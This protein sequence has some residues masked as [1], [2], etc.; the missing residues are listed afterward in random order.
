MIN[1]L[2]PAKLSLPWDRHIIHRDWL[3]LILHVL[4]LGGAV[5]F[6]KTNGGE[7]R[8]VRFYFCLGFLCSILS[9]SH[10]IFFIFNAIG[11]EYNSSFFEKWGLGFLY[12]FVSIATAFICYKIVASINK[13]KKLQLTT[14]SSHDGESYHLT[15]ATNWQRFFHW[16]LDSIIFALVLTNIYWIQK[17]HL[18]NSI[19]NDAT[20]RIV[21]WF[22]IVVV[23]TI[24]FVFF[25]SIF[26]ATPAKMLTETRVTT[27]NGSKPV[28]L[29]VIGR[30]LCRS[31]PF[32][33]IS[34]LFKGKWHDKIS[35]THVLKEERTG[36]KAIFYL[37]FLIAI[38]LLVTGMY[39]GIDKY[40]EYKAEKKYKEE[41]EIKIKTQ[42]AILKKITSDY[43]IMAKGENDYSHTYFFKV[44]AVTPSIITVSKIDMSAAPYEE[45]VA[46]AKEAWQQQKDTLKRFDIKRE[47]LEKTIPV[48]YEASQKSSGKTYHYILPGDK[49]YEIKDFLRTSGPKLKDHFS[50]FSHTSENNSA[51][52][53]FMNEGEAGSVVNFINKE[54]DLSLITTLPL[55][56]STRE[57]FSSN[58]FEL[59]FKNYEYGKEYKF[60][61]VL[62]DKAHNQ[63]KYLVRSHNYSLDMIEIFE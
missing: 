55:A 26:G 46:K 24:W 20:A 34:F 27:Y 31:I 43:F 48:N 45:S 12:L 35:H 23:R 57:K 39:V 25:E 40:G 60:I 56:I 8:L 9:V 1:M 42:R 16:L 7:T 33:F 21:L 36:Y 18:G 41:I 4:L 10:N 11:T 2:C 52:I 63:Y 29:N 5:L 38:I 59:S 62:E 47:V 49:K 30:S 6:K 61:L 19:Y 53:Q 15:D 51:S 13:S 17:I 32:D 54:G 50:S 14:T 3:N 37:W 44:E 22:F 28:F 58:R